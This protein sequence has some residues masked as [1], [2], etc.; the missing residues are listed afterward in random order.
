MF[1]KENKVPEHGLKLEK[2]AGSATYEQSKT[3]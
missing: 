1:A 3:V 2:V